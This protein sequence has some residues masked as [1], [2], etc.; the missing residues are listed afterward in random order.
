MCAVL[1]AGC[2]VPCSVLNKL[3]PLVSN[4]STDSEPPKKSEPLYTTTRCC[5]VCTVCAM[6]API[7]GDVGLYVAVS[8]MCAGVHVC[9]CVCMCERASKP[10]PK[11]SRAERGQT[12]HRPP[13]AY[14]SL[15]NISPSK[16]FSHYA[17]LPLQATTTACPFLVTL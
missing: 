10:H 1:R 13:I 2:G 4:Q 9:G 15:I 12:R 5:V 14:Y 8:R 11:P 7:A 16:N 6:C 3:V 17:Y